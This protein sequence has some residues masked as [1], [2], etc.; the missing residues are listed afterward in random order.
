MLDHSASALTDPK[1]VTAVIDI[2]ALLLL[3]FYF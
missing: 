3:L 2:N 1:L